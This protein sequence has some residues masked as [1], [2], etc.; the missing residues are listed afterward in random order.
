MLPQLTASME[1]CNTLPAFHAR[2]P[3]VKLHVAGVLHAIIEAVQSTTAANS[4]IR[5]LMTGAN[6]EETSPIHRLREQLRNDQARHIR[7]EAIDR[8]AVCVRAWNMIASHKPAP[9]KGRI[10]GMTQQNGAIVFPEPI[11]TQ[12]RSKTLTR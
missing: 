12:R 3:V 2:A 4:F 9:A 5:A 6:L 8:L 7:A 1:F 10:K 11:P